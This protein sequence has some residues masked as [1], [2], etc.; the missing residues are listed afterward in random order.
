M[1]ARRSTKPKGPEDQLGPAGR[2]LWDAVLEPLE[3]DTWEASILIEACR[4]A[5]RLDLLAAAAVGAPLTV[6]NA[7]HDLVVNPLLS[8]ARQQSLALARLI[9]SLRLPD[10]LAGEGGRPQRRGGARGPY[11]VRDAS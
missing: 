11:R 10:G 5:D 8:E 2:K 7:R 1:T 3:L 9:A 4:T 6:E